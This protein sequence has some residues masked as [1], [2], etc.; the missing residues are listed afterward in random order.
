MAWRLNVPGVEWV[1]RALKLRS[2]EAPRDVDEN[3]SPVLDV[4]QG[5]QSLATWE[6]RDVVV[7]SA[8]ATVNVLV[9]ADPD[10][11]QL[12]VMHISK[13]GAAAATDSVA[14]QLQTEPVSPS[15]V[16]LYK[17]AAFPQEERGWA[18]LG[19]GIQWWVVPPRFRLQ[20]NVTPVPTLTD[21]IRC[22]MLV[23]KV[24]AGFK[25]W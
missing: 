12:V 14:V 15:A 3:I 4:F 18:E 2:G 9:P 1:T 24:P 20:I 8:S 13:V 25:A 19:N 7:T 22:R 5:G 11:M 6:R 17:D 16:S 23:C 21:E 10:L